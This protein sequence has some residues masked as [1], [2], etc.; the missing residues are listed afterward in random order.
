MTNPQHGDALEAYCERIV[1][2]ASTWGYCALQ[3]GHEGDCWVSRI[4]SAPAPDPLDRPPVH[5]NSR[6]VSSV[7][8]ADII[9]SEAGQAELRRTR[10][11][12]L[13]E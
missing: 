8:A 13:T 2:G 4:R 5:V 6:G 11:A 12:K 1:T 9:R 7:R 10:D 3:A